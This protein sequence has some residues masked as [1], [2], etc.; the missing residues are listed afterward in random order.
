MMRSS[1]W[2][3]EGGKKAPR[4]S[5]VTVHQFVPENHKVDKNSEVQLHTCRNNMW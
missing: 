1:S 4:N 5:N 3:S 2:E